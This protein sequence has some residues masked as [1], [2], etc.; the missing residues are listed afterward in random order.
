MASIKVLKKIHEQQE[1]K[2]LVKDLIAL[3]PISPV[4][5]KDSHPLEV[6]YHDENP[7][8]PPID[9]FAPYLSRK[10]TIKR[11]ERIEKMRIKKRPETALDFQLTNSRSSQKRYD[12]NSP[13]QLT[14]TQGIIKVN[15]TLPMLPNK[16]QRSLSP[17]PSKRNNDINDLNTSS[18]NSN[19]ISSYQTEIYSPS[20]K[21][22]RNKQK[23]NKQANHHNLSYASSHANIIYDE[24]ALPKL[25]NKATT[26]GNPSN[27]NLKTTFITAQEIS[28]PQMSDISLHLKQE[29]T[30]DKIV[31]GTATMALHRCIETTLQMYFLA[32]KVLYFHDISSVKVLY[33][34]STT[35]YCPHGIGLIGYVQYSRE[36]IRLKEAQKHI[37]YNFSIEGNQIMPNNH[38]LIFPIF[39]GFSN[40]K[41]I[42]VVMRKKDSPVFTDD[43][44]K[45]V[46]YF[47]CKVKNYA[48]WL[49][50]PALDDNFASDLMKTY[51]L[52]QFVDI[53]SEKLSSLFTCRAAEIWRLNTDTNIISKYT[54]TSKKAVTIPSSESGIGGY[55]LRNCS[56][57]SC[58]TQRV[59]AAYYEK[60][61]GCRDYSCL[62]IPVKDPD[63]PYYYAVVLRGKRTPQFFTDN[64]EKIL[65][66]VIPYVIAA[67][68][69]AE[70]VEKNHKALKD[71]MHQQK[72]LRALLEVAEYLSCQLKMDD[73][74]PNIM[75]RACELVKADR[76]SLFMVNETHDK[77]VT[78]FQGGLANAIE[79]PI[80]AGIVGFTATTGE[81]LN[82]KDA[83]EDP[84]F[85]RATDL[86]TGYRTLSILSVPIFD[87]RSQI[88]GVTEMINKLDGIFTQ[89]DE[90]MIKIFNVFCG[91]SL[92]NA[93]L[94]RASIDLSLQLRSFLDISYS[95]SQPQT[96][97]KCIEEILRNSRKVIGA[98]RAALYMLENSGISFDPYVLDEDI[99]AKIRKNEMKKQEDIE[100][101]LGVKRAIISKLLQG[102]TSKFDQEKLLEEEGRNKV[103]EHVIT[104]KE[105]LME[106][107]PMRP[108]R[109]IICVP[110][111]S[112]DR[113]IMGAV[114][115]QWKKNGSKFTFDEQK[116]LE[117]Y[118]VFLSISLERSRL[119]SI[120]QLGTIEVEIQ[121][122]ITQEERT[123]ICIPQ[124]L[125]LT[126]AQMTQAISK[127]FD[128]SNFKGMDLFKI[129]YYF[130]SI[131]DILKTFK[132]HSEMFYHFLHDVKETYNAVPY[133]NWIHACDV[134][135]YTA[136]TLHSTG[137]DTVLNKFEIFAL[138][139]ASICHDANHDGF[140][141]QYN[142]KAQT[143]L[144]ILFRNQSVMETHHCSVMIGVLTKDT[145]NLLYSLD[146]TESTKMWTL[147]INLI[148]AT[149]MARHFSIMEK[150]EQMIRRNRPSDPW[151]SRE[152][153]RLLV[154]QLLIKSADISNV[155]RKFELANK[156]CSY[157]CEEYFIQGDLEKAYGMEISPMNDREKIEKE[158]LQID[159]YRNVCLPLF[160]MDAKISPATEVQVEQIKSNMKIWEEKLLEKM[161]EEK[162]K[163][164]AEA[165]TLAS[166]NALAMT[167]ES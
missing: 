167:K 50:Q 147:L 70:I 102:Q 140:S 94:Y 51:R 65:A 41:G 45:F 116:L 112:S 82:I 67:L 124:R 48:R 93:R 145:S 144:G 166:Q 61:D 25:A 74:I 114:L 73:L 19:A 162:N 27:N 155:S 14:K 142:V 53:I 149:D 46:E 136:Y 100:D 26:Y 71:S 159:F 15:K 131:F 95:L 161:E 21:E 17:N 139:I 57:I 153:D 104:L 96:I 36:I 37:S 43:D 16:N 39:D 108:E 29:Q 120:A 115:M 118:S 111:I 60:T 22:N 119:K 134:T 156:W 5:T 38:V 152:N 3:R 103:I 146:D 23:N 132:I 24:D 8:P 133:H 33:C 97:K 121:T 58:I 9:Q 30:F 62:S 52:T 35:A 64:D 80:N 10:L 130:F 164:M 59:H 113:A 18:Q 31:A 76:C 56:P 163:E 125:K 123:Q 72:N 6:L 88:C 13:S 7:P 83:Y 69:S 106:N 148:L 11:N 42:V 20:D 12:P 127:D 129:N 110:I 63:N 85:N 160:E 135:Q 44:E 90:S 141:N 34:P 138:L 122:W 105:S 126:E 54:S 40:V 66:R 49:F 137:L 28:A 1:R 79:I 117:S 91:I 98:V 151:F 92:E 87:E 165:E 32:E 99:E 86:A 89:E 157:L 109:S 77:L 128:P 68:T 55:V 47:Q 2:S 150:A 107:D 158:K 4:V 143:P 75:T 81:I 101:S 154:M 78:S 84:R